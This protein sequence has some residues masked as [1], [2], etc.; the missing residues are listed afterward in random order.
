MFDAGVA[1]FTRHGLAGARVERIAAKAGV[2]KQRIYFYF[3]SKEGLFVE[4]WKHYY[5]LVCEEDKYYT[6]LSVNDIPNL[7]DIILQRY[8]GFHKKYPEFWKIFAWENMSGG[9]HVS[10]VAQ[11]RASRFDHLRRLYEEGQRL[12]HFSPKVS[13]ESFILVIT[14]IS[15]FYTSNKTTMS[16][17]LG[18]SLLDEASETRIRREVSTMLFGRDPA[19][20]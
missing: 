14:S 20:P 15:F 9:R 8:M 10:E 1:E 4:I 13:F 5:N 3:K 2:N 17:T 12:G 18:L 11:T 6:S 16:T 19:R 7:G